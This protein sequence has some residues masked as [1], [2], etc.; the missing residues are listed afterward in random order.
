LRGIHGKA[1][2]ASERIESDQHQRDQYPIQIKDGEHPPTQ[3][4]VAVC[5]VQ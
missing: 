3:G 4:G 5:A 1:A 2:R